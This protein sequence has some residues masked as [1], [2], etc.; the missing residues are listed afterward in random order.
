MKVTIF[1]VR[2]AGSAKVSSTALAPAGSMTPIRL[3]SARTTCA[4]LPST[5]AVQPGK[6]FSDTMSAEPAGAGAVSLTAIAPGSYRPIVTAVGAATPS[7]AGS[8]VSTRADESTIAARVGE[9]PGSNT[10]AS[11]CASVPRTMPFATHAAGLSP[12]R[13]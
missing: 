3:K 13:R 2:Y 4:T 1:P 8:T 11:A 12:G 7:L 9:K 5:V 10:V 6:K